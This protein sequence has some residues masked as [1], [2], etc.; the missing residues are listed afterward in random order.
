MLL[1]WD[2][3][4]QVFEL[5]SPDSFHWNASDTVLP[6]RKRRKT[7]SKCIFTDSFYIFTILSDNRAHSL[8]KILPHKFTL[9]YLFTGFFNLDKILTVT[10]SRVTAI[11]CVEF[12][13][14]PYSKRQENKDSY[15]W[16]SLKERERKKLPFISLFWPSALYIYFVSHLDFWLLKN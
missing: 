13:K 16:H 10:K 9:K 5:T 8:V 6:E 15:H 2:P 4:E 14:L 11:N 7:T 12:P 3:T 1:T